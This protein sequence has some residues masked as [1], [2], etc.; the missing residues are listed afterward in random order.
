METCFG[1]SEQLLDVAR[2]RRMWAAMRTLPR[3]AADV[4]SHGDL[5]PGNVLVSGG[6]L[7][8]I[9]DVG[10]LGPADPALDLVAAVSGPIVSPHVV[11]RAAPSRG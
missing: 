9:L 6:R 10:G 4:M 1:Q 8:G 2:L 3:V 5:I 11:L 7:A